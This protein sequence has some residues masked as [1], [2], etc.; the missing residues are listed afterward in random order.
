MFWD[1]NDGIKGNT[2]W[3]IL[4]F[5]INFYGIISCEIILSDIRPSWKT[6]YVQH[7]MFSWV[8][9]PKTKADGKKAV[10]EYFLLNFF[11]YFCYLFIYIYI[12]YLFI[13]IYLF[14]L[15]S[16]IYS[17]LIT[18]CKFLV[19]IYR[20]TKILIILWL[21]KIYLIDHKL[22]KKKKKLLRNKVYEYYLLIF[23]LKTAWTILMIF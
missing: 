7:F 17:H 4:N 14:F 22:L 19:I 11:L 6:T 15:A 5:L 3:I 10:K 23:Y 21:S 9:G 2:D 1:N 18:E 16:L 13:Y 12:L 8:A 20:K